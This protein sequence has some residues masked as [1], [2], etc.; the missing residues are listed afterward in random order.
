MGGER[1]GGEEGGGGGGVWGVGEGREVG[2]GGRR[3]GAKMGKQQT[4]V[5]RWGQS[6]EW[7]TPRHSRRARQLLLH[8]EG[9]DL[10]AAR[11]DGLPPPPRR[12]LEGNAGR[13]AF[14]TATLHR[15]LASVVG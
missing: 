14:R 6:S 3:E 8:K 12:V 2:G 4:K 1:L 5:R 9:R 7:G 10:K 13:P 11:L 15:Y